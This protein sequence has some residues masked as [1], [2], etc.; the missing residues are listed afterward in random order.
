HISTTGVSHPRNLIVLGDRS[1][2]SLIETYL[3][4]N[5]SVYFSNA[6]TEIVAGEDSIVDHCKLQLE[7]TDAFHLATLQVEQGRGCLFRS[8]TASFGATL[9]RTEINAVL[10]D[11]AD[12]TLNGLYM[13]GGNQHIDNRTSIDHARPHGSSHE[14]YKGILDG[15]SSAVFIGRI[16]VRKDAQK[17][18]A[19]QTNRNLVLSEEATINTKPELQIHA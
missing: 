2:A 15:H 17:T 14:L 13:A 7:S 6:V 12:C 4:A 10:S 16:I 1:Q 11:S 8:H 19:K 5:G 3:G 9:A 18:D